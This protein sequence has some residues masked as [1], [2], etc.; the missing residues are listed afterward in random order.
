MGKRVDLNS[1]MN[2][3]LAD[4]AIKWRRDKNR[5]DFSPEN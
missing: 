1:G 3:N 4:R 5:D 2:D